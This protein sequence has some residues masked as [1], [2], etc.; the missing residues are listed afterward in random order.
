MISRGLKAYTRTSKEV[1][2]LASD[3]HQVIS[4]LM[5]G[6]LERMQR[7][8]AQM[9]HGDTEG[10][11]TSLMRVIDIIEALQNG[12]NMDVNPDISNN[13]YELYDYMMQRITQANIKNDTDIVD[14]VYSLLKPISE[15]WDDMPKDEIQKGIELLEKQ[16]FGNA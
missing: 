12:L 15:A 7:G 13:F 5:K 1:Q 8:K 10:K 6:A 14:E 9:Q 3:P 4:L 2:L 11:H 16:K